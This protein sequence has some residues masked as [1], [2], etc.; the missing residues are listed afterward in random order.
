VDAHPALLGGV[1]EEQPAEAPE[2]LA[3]QRLLG[4]LVDQEHAATRV[5][6]LRCG[7][8]PGQAVTDDDDVRIHGPDPNRPRA[9]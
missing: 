3:A 4:L 7:G 6:D 8:E 9:N 1:D 2:R 5:G